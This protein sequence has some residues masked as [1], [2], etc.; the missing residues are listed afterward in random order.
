MLFGLPAVIERTTDSVFT[1]TLGHAWRACGG[2][3]FV[4]QAGRAGDLQLPHCERLFRALIAFL[5]HTGIV[6]RHPPRAPR[7]RTRTTSARPDR[8]R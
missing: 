1:S 4:I 3:N 2:E 6:T 7:T 5:H 8:C